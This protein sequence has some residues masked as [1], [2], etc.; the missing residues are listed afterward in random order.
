MKK[1][2]I[3]LILIICLILTSC[4]PPSRVFTFN[5]KS[6][7]KVD[8]IL[9]ISL[10]D[11]VKYY[12]NC[13]ECTDFYIRDLNESNLLK[14]SNQ[15]DSVIIIDIRLFTKEFDSKIYEQSY[16]DYD[17][18][19]TWF[20]G[21]NILSQVEKPLYY[22]VLTPRSTLLL[23]ILDIYGSLIQYAIQNSKT[24]ELKDMGRKSYVT[25]DWNKS[26][27]YLQENIGK[28]SK[29]TFIYRYLNENVWRVSTF[30]KYL[31]NVKME[32]VKE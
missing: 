27:N 19:S 14:I 28:E 16:N 21:T 30:S 2:F 32:I 15:T 22:K 18:V 6:I 17:I 25:M 9:K 23:P 1:L 29:L 20:L 10:G 24:I 11:T 13:E 26:Q 7:D 4:V 8:N 12:S 5:S 3:Q 31:T